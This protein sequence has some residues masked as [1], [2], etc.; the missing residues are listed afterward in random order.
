M[1][2]YSLPG[3]R[4][5]TF[6]VL[7]RVLPQRGNQA[8]YVCRCECGKEHVRLASALLTGRFEPCG[9]VEPPGQSELPGASVVPETVVAPEA[10]PARPVPRPRPRA[11]S[12]EPHRE[13]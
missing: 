11:E 4:L 1:N 3:S 10:K 8:S 9:C 2:I 6:T 13:G 7:R 5:G 12:P